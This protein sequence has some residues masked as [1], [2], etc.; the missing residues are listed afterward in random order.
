MQSR[1]NEGTAPSLKRLSSPLVGMPF[2][3][4]SIKHLSNCTGN[5]LAI[6]I[7]YLCNVCCR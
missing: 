6:A 5:E 7:A 1:F 3:G 2:M 4:A